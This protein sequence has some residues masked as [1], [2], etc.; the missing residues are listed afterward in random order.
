MGLKGPRTAARGIGASL[1][2]DDLDKFSDEQLVQL[3][4]LYEEAIKFEPLKEPT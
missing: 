1:T 3:H 4:A 2:H